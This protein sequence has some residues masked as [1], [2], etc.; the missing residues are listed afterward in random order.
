MDVN[1]T[2]WSIPFSL[3]DLLVPGYLTC[4]P[5]LCKIHGFFALLGCFGNFSAIVLVSIYRC[6]NIVFGNRFTWKRVHIAA[7]VVLGWVSSS[8]ITLPPVTG[9]ASTHE[10]TLGTHHCSPSW[11]DSC[12]FYTVCIC[13][14]YIISIPT[15][16]ICYA[17]IQKKVHK[18]A[19]R[20]DQYR[21]GSQDH[22]GN[23]YHPGNHG[24]T[25]GR[26]ILK[27]KVSEKDSVRQINRDN[28]ATGTPSISSTRPKRISLTTFHSIPSVVERVVETKVK[29]ENSSV[30]INRLK[31]IK[32]KAFMRKQRSEKK[33]AI[34][35]MVLILTSTICWTP[36]FIVHSCRL[37]I[38]P[39]HAY[40]VFAMWLAYTNAALDPMIY[41][42]L[43][44]KIRAAVWTQI[45]LPVTLISSLWNHRRS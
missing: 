42:V 38:H 40:N 16:I 24:D 27:R 39:S 20:M 25:Q 15:L 32:F 7:M 23:E 35:G 18:S 29:R 19:E 41:T 43:N 33:V 11:E 8:L 4:F 44:N 26:S 22:Q 1:V 31:A 17:L 9:T 30:R 13:I 10:Y 12:T 37:A 28:T 21:R 34:S 3:A 36:Y 5:R 6:V 14:I 2:I 45:R